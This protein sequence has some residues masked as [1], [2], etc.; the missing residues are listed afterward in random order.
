MI[1]GIMKAP[2]KLQAT[3]KAIR[4]KPKTRLAVFKNLLPAQQAQICL[5]LSK[6][7]VY[8]LLTRLEDLE[9]AAILENLD[10]DEATDILQL[11]PA[12]KR[13]DLLEI[14]SSRMKHAVERLLGFDPK[15]AAGLMN[16]DYIQVGENETI[17]EVAKQFKIH[18]K[19]TGRLPAI[20]VLMSDG[21]LAGYLPGHEL[22]FAQLKDKAKK[23]ARRI[24]TIRH[25][26]THEEAV[27]LFRAY[28]H[29]K[30]AVIGAN[31]NVMG[32]IYSDD[33]ARIL[34]EQTAASLYDFAGVSKEESVFG[35]A[36]EKIKF[37]Y[38]WLIINLGTSFLAAFVVSMFD[39]TIAKYVLLAV[40]MPIIAGMG[41]NA[42]TQAMAVMVRGIT[43][44]QIDFKSSLGALKNELLSGF[45]NGVI[46]GALVAIVIL[47]ANRD[48]L[49]AL[50][51]FLAMIVNLM[52]AAAA[53]TMAPL[54]MARLGKDPASSATIFITTATDVLG[55]FAFLGLAAILL[56]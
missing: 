11:F 53:G 48:P 14:L 24:A 44:K 34:R 54:L 23:Y 30:I 15:T 8:D 42:G 55:F 40:Y 49:L 1:D 22:G 31:D 21:K 13:T 43:L 47:F 5:I 41:G 12:P 29:A 46:N 27:D 2:N 20:I 25:S 4:T 45:V 9:I 17:A 16:V 37:R 33:I 28:P 56:P 18:E 50:V 35:S 3:I 19:R 52:V 10:P 26:A 7:L 6:H 51:L 38:K 36:R 39:Q 32:I